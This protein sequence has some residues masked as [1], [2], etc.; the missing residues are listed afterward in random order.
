PRTRRPRPPGSWTPYRT[1]SVPRAPEWCDSMEIV[2]ADQGSR[3]E[4]VVDL[5]AIAHNVTLLAQR[6]AGSGAATMAVVKADGY[7]HGAVPVARAAL[8]AGATWLGACSLAE[9][10]DLRAAGLTAPVLAWL[11]P[12]HTDYAPGVAAGID[13]TATGPDQLDAIA[14][15][16]A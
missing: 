16:A 6:A 1:R 2:M 5:D 7:G 9:A 12:V 8:A 15:A 14:D 10:L 4:V 3:A 11:D 13:L